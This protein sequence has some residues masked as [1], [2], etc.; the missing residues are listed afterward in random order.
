[1]RATARASTAS[2]RRSKRCA[3]AVVFR[4]R[5]RRRCSTRCRRARRATR[6]TPRSG[7]STPSAPTAASAGLAGLAAPQPVVT[8]Y[9]L[10]LDTPE[11]MGEAAAAQRA[12]PL[13]KLKLG[14]DGD[15][16][17]VARG[18]RRR[19]GGAA[20]RRRQ[21]GLDARRLTAEL[22]PA[23]RRARGRADRAAAAGRRR[24]RAGAARA[25]DP[26]LRRRILP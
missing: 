16:E 25:S 26:D 2:W 8:A 17:R 12:R 19:A 24:R 1:M 6:S 18:A 9:T 5:P 13:L 23:L 20:D 21:R 22:S 15:L 11:R 7:T 10:S 4:P 3:G 14:G